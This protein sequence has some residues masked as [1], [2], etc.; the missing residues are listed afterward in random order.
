[1]SCFFIYKKQES[2]D[3]ENKK[4]LTNF[5]LIK[6]SEYINISSQTTPADNKQQ[7]VLIKARLAV[8]SV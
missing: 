1:M 6:L 2:T 7:E 4:K 3:I 8:S 5:P